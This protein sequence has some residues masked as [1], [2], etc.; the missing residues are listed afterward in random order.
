MGVEGGVLMT[1]SLPW[2]LRL[3]IWGSLKVGPPL[4]N[5][6]VGAEFLRQAAAASRRG[7]SNSAQPSGVSGLVRDALPLWCGFG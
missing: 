6:L 3:K 1:D 5:T 7:P 4:K 2:A